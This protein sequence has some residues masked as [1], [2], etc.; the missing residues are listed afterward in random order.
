MSNFTNEFI[1]IGDNQDYAYLSDEPLSDNS[2]FSYQSM[3]FLANFD[4]AAA[5]RPR[6]RRDY[7]YFSQQRGIADECCINACT[8]EQLKK[9]CQ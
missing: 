1:H 7:Y 2:P 5:L 3:P 4:S 6:E 9:Y 8:V